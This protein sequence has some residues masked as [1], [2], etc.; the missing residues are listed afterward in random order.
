MT[1]SPSSIETNQTSRLLISLTNINPAGNAQV[2]QGDVL[3]IYLALGNGAVQSVDPNLI[4]GGTVFQTGDWVVDQSA[5]INPVT[6]VYQGPNQLWP[7]LES[8]AVSLQIQPPASVSVGEIVLRVPTDGRYGAQE[9][10]VSTINLV[11]ADLLAPSASAISSLTNVTAVV[12]PQGPAGPA[13]PAGPQGVPG[14]EG[15]QGAQGSVGPPGPQGPQGPAGTAGPQGA[16]G[17]VGPVG[18]TGPTGAAGATGLAG[19]KG[20]PGDPGL[21][22]PTGSVG[23]IGPQGPA[24]PV[25]IYW[26]KNSGQIALAGDPEKLPSPASL[27]TLSLPEGGYWVLAHVMILNG[28]ATAENAQCDLGGSGV[29]GATIAPHWAATIPL[30]TTVSGGTLTLE[31][32]INGAATVLAGSAWMTAVEGTNI[33]KQ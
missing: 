31:C 25:N 6:L 19:P 13:G 15:P 10:L 5:G 18:P 30:Q 21:A 8:V 27:I 17:A 4:L 29:A 23:P 22:G 11:T 12:G 2:L 28:G 1:T 32:S 7:A 16:A 20:P 26:T 9:W 33:V 24:G 3:R 14:T